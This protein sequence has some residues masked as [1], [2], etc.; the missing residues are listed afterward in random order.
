MG[1]EQISLAVI[2]LSDNPVKAKAYE[3]GVVAD[4]RDYGVEVDVVNLRDDEFINDIISGR[5]EYYKDSVYT[6]DLAKL[7]TT[8]T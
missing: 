7:V 5:L 6:G 2:I 1:C 4:A 3:E 8:V